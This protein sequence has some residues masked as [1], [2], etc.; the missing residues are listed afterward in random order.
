M[1][2]SRSEIKL[3]KNPFKVKKNQEDSEKENLI[4]KN[5][6]LKKE[7][8]R[9]NDIIKRML[10]ERQ[11]YFDKIQERDRTFFSDNELRA[12]Q[13]ENTENE[14]KIKE[15]KN[16]LNNKNNENDNLVKQINSLKSESSK[17]TELYNALLSKMDKFI[18]ACNKQ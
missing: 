4:K 6:E 3:S 7:I 14:R 1:N 2:R 9:L 17:M 18:E 13:N 8:K 11:Y 12:I 16:E 10:E 5:V 15:L